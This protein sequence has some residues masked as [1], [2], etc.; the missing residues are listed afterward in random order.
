MKDF[1]IRI[2]FCAVEKPIPTKAALAVFVL[3]NEPLDGQA[4]GLDTEGN[5]A[6][7]A[8]VE[9]RGFG[10]ETGSTLEI[11]GAVGG[12]PRQTVLV[13]LGPRLSVNDLVLE[14]AAASALSLANS[15]GCSTLVLQMDKMAPDQAARAAFG[16]LLGSYRF[17]RLLSRVK[18][19]TENPVQE[20]R[21]ACTEPDLASKEFQTLR[22]LG[23][24]VHFARDLVSEPGNLLFPTAFAERLLALREF[25][26]EIEILGEEEMAR[27]GMG[28][29]LGVGQGSVRESQL[30]VLRWNGGP[31][32]EPPVAFVGKG[33]C[34]DTGGISLKTGGGMESMIW[35]MAGAAAVAGGIFALAARKAPINAVGVVALAENMPGGNAIRPG[36]ILTS[37]SGQTV[38]I[39]STDAEGRLVL[40]DAIWYCQK[41]YSPS[42]VID[43]ATLTGASQVALGSEFAAMFA[44]DDGLAD[45]LESAGRKSGDLVW[46]LPLSPF[47]EKALDTPRADMKNFQSGGGGSIIGALFVKRFLTGSHVKWAHID[48]TPTAWWD[49]SQISTSP[50]GATG[51]G[52]RLIDEFAR[53]ISDRRDGQ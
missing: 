4:A 44:N 36:D 9:R 32:E 17:D 18:P 12:E 14:R 30:A 40:A 38:E 45:L 28:C 42:V 11:L 15:T 50:T 33:I 51:F 27:E 7:S 53:Q 29:L 13:G 31:S 5:N 43:L 8:L 1:P 46:R 26:V 24:A 47:M 21:I 41:V 2:E 39:I 35:D 16:M 3:A 52:V 48:M 6:V 49:P 19:G 23:R 37:M 25:G 10:G 34:F 20:I 22:S